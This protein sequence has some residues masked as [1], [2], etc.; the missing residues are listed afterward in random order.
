MLHVTSIVRG[1]HENKHSMA[2]RTFCSVEL[3]NGLGMPVSKSVDSSV[4][5]K[6]KRERE[7]NKPP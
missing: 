3:L 6:K 5:P 1:S 2:T 7:M 4:P